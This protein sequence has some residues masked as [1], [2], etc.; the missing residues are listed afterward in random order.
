MCMLYEVFLIRACLVVFNSTVGFI[1]TEY[2]RGLDS[3]LKGET[4]HVL[5]CGS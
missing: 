4:R 3:R 5:C 1:L 2:R